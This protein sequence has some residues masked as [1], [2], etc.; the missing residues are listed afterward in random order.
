MG[1]PAGAEFGELFGLGHFAFA[2]GDLEAAAH[3]EVA[4]GETSGR[5][6]LKMRII[7]ADQRPMPLTS[8]RRA[9]ISSSARL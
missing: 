9:M 8:V 3:T 4:D 1:R 2:I 6:R 7:S 5:P